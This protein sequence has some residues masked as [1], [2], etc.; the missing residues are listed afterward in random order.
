[1]TRKDLNQCFEDA[2]KACPELENY[3][4][5]DSDARSGKLVEIVKVKK[6]GAISSMTNFMKYDEMAYY[7][8]GYINKAGNCYEPD[9]PAIDTPTEEDYTPFLVVCKDHTCFEVNSKLGN[10]LLEILRKPVMRDETISSPDY[11]I[12]VSEI[13]HVIKNPS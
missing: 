8:A 12:T 13:I 5:H 1:M 7:L 9:K 11:F 2:K 3:R 10:T 6:S 4:L